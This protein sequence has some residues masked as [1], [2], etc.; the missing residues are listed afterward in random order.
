MAAPTVE[1]SGSTGVIIGVIIGVIVSGIIALVFMRRRCRQKQ[2]PE[3]PERMP[4]GIALPEVGIKIGPSHFDAVAAVE[5]GSRVRAAESAA[6]REAEAKARAAE[7]KAA[8]EAKEAYDDELLAELDRLMEE[9][10]EMKARAAKKASPPTIQILDPAVT[11]SLATSRFME[12]YNQPES[13]PDQLY[14]LMT[15]DCHR[16]P[17]RRAARYSRIGSS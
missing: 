7:V 17:E 11:P 14:A 16:L 12:I 4:G 2:P 1:S 15:S 8:A 5:R 9:D 13:R 3:R 10:L 6:D